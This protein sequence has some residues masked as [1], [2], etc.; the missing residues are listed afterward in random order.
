MWKLEEHVLK[1]FKIALKYVL[2]QPVLWQEEAGFQ[3]KFV[4]YVL[5]FVKNVKMNAE[6]LR[7]NIVKFV[8]MFVVNVQLNVQI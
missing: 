1:L 4:S 5:Q 2:Q 7:M 3:R 6:R 8:L